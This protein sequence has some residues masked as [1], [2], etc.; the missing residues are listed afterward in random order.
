M[1]LREAFQDYGIHLT[2]TEEERLVRFQRLLYEKNRVMDLTS[3][4]EEDSTEKHLIDSVL[5]LF[6]CPPG[7]D[8]RRIADVGSGAGLPGIPLAVTHPALEITLLE[9]Q[10][11]RCR[12]LSECVRELDLKNVRILNMRAEDAGRDPVC[13]QA[14][15]AAAAR[16]VAP[17]NIL[18]EYLAPLVR[19]GGRMLCWKGPEARSECEAAQYAFREL[20][21]T[22]AECRDVPL[23]SGT[24]ILVTCVCTGNLPSR[25][26]R[27]SGIPSKRPLGGEYSAK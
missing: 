3:I 14:F 5:P 9:A 24:R 22:D 26:P 18:A 13:R 10:E 20:G 11:K 23:R 19:P 6:V 16:A 4:P 8:I 25:Y 1:T 17:M 7:E 12:F 2:E 27:R 15:D 21:C